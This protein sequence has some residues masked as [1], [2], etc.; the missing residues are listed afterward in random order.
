MAPLERFTVEVGSMAVEAFMAV[1]DSTAAADSTVAA[2]M[3]EEAVTG[4]RSS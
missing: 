2:V 3:V 4:K 1:G